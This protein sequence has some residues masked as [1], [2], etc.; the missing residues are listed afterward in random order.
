[1][2]IYLL[3]SLAP[4]HDRAVLCWTDLLPADLSAYTLPAF[5]SR[6]ERARAYGWAA[7]TDDAGAGSGL[8]PGTAERARL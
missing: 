5:M 3:G 2:F 8:P 1:M 6:S 4:T 7:P